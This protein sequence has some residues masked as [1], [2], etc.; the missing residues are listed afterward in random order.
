MRAI[1]LLCGAALVA[2]A[3]ACSRPQAEA[4]VSP[5]VPTVAV[6]KVTRGDVSQVLTVA[7]EFRPFQEIDVHAKVAGYVKS[8]NVDVGDRV[9][10]GQLLAVLEIPELQ[11]ELV[12]DEASVKRANEEV[13]R[14]QADLERAQSAHEVTHLASSRLTST[15]CAG[16]RSI[17][18]PA[19]RSA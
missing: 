16:S 13:N 9:K 11:D 2:C 10:P 4:R 6:A 8:I 18:P 14:A 12:Q 1:R 17:S 19:T 3:A 5:D 7:A 15:S